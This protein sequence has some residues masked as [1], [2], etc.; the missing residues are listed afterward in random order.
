MVELL[1]GIIDV[2]GRALAPAAGDAAA[3]DGVVD[4]VLFRS[5]S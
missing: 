2:D 1:E 4:R 5:A 3:A